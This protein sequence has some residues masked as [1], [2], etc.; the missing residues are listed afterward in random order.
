E[1]YLD[2]FYAR[3]TAVRQTMSSEVNSRPQSFALTPK[4]IGQRAAASRNVAD[5][6]THEG[7]HAAAGR[8]CPIRNPENP[9]DVEKREVWIQSRVDGVRS[10]VASTPKYDAIGITWDR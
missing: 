4:I 5:L 6:L 8:K 10:L 1:Q 9:R 2:S 3:T 7:L